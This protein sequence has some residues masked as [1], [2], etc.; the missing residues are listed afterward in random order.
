MKKLVPLTAVLMLAGC[1]TT[2]STY[3]AR[4]ITTIDP[5]TG[6]PVVVVDDGIGE[7]APVDSYDV[8]TCGTAVQWIPD[9]AK[10]LELA[11]KEDKLLLVVH[12]SGNFQS[13]EG[14]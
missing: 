2:A 9:H 14:T 7:I 4:A 3:G 13:F 11:Q 10:A 8:V 5:V 6:A 1:S 12:L